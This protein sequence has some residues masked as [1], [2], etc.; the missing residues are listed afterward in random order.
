MASTKFTK[1]NLQRFRK[2]YPYIRREPRNIYCSDKEA[3]IEVGS[4]TFT[5]TNSGTYIFQE[6]FP[7]VPTISA[8]SVDSSSNNQANV[9]VFVTSVSTSEITIEVSQNFTGTVDFHALW[10]SP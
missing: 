8:I 2:V 9:N 1:R 10:V 4:I 6:N 3:V 5:N 7:S